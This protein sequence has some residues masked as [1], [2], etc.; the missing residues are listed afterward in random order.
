MKSLNNS[1]LNTFAVII[2]A[3]NAEKTLERCIK[4]VLNQTIKANE[5]IIIND[6]SEDKTSEIIE[7]FTSQ[8]LPITHAHQKNLGVSTSRNRGIQLAEAN[9][10][11]FLD[12]DDYWV[13][14]KIETHMQHLNK[15]KNCVASFTNYLV[16]DSS[17]HKLIDNNKSNHKY[18]ITKQ[19]LA[20]AKAVIH[21]S[22][23]SIVCSRSI[24]EQIG[25]F[26][27]HLNFGEDLDMWIRLAQD[28]EICEIKELGTIISKNEK[29]SQMKLLN[30]KSSWLLSDT[31]LYIWRKNKI[32]FETRSDRKSARLLLRIEMRRHRFSI[33]KIIFDFPINLR[34][35]DNGFYLQIYRNYPNYLLYLFTDIRFEFL[36]VFTRLCDRIACLLNSLHFFGKNRK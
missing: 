15:H 4:S 1:T 19:N 23:S 24:F 27:E 5:I 8:N 32:E 30:D 20:L 9:Q 29:S 14:T 16:E 22:A 10:I 17:Q 36:V 6:G 21:G 12:A 35:I 31:Y 11:M 18:Q 25:G 26:D 13:S 2:P 7:N 28:N 3:Y 33:R 34:E